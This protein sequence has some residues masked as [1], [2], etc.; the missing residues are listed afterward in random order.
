M[1]VLGDAEVKF[2]ALDVLGFEVDGEGAFG[3]GAEKDK[4]VDGF[5]FVLD[6]VFFDRGASTHS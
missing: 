2:S 5:G 4:A 1:G 6:L 3:A